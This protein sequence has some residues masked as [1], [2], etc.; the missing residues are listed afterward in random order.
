M[1]FSFLKKK[2]IRSLITPPSKPSVTMRHV[3]SKEAEKELEAAGLEII[4]GGLLDYYQDYWFTT[5]QGWREIQDYIYKVYKYIS[6]LPAMHA[7]K[8]CDDFAFLFKGLVGGLFGLNYCAYTEGDM[9]LGWHA[10]ITVKTENGL[11]LIEPNPDFNL[12]QPFEIG[13]H[14]YHP[15]NVML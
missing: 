9:P 15:K 8:D 2:K 12:L 4:R 11:K 13:E 14:D 1:C 7:R 3:S 5:E 6:A 10:F